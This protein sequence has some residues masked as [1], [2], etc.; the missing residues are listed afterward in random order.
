MP[1]VLSF[2]SYRDLADSLA[3]QLHA[4]RGEADALAPWTAGVIVASSG[5][6]GA[7]AAALIARI[8]S[9]IAGLPLLSMENFARSVLNAA[10]EFP[11]VASENERHLAMRTAIRRFDDPLFDSRGVSSM[12]E[13][14]YR[15]MRDAGLTLDDLAGAVERSKRLRNRERTWRILTA[16][17]EYESLIRILGAI[18]PADLFTN[19]ARAIERK[20]IVR[21][22]HVAGFYDM[23]GVQLRLVD[24]L[25][26]TG[27][28]AGVWM[29]VGAENEN[30]AYAQPLAQHFSGGAEL[31]RAK[32][33]LHA[34]VPV[35]TRHETLHDEHRG[36]CARIRTLLDDGVPARSIGI[37]SRSFE[38]WDLELLART[39]VEAGFAIRET[40]ETPLISQRI[41]RGALT[42]LRLR[43]N[44]FH[45]SDV[46]EL[47]RDGVRT[48]THASI[49]RLDAET[50]R[51]RIAG[52]TSEELRALRSKKPA[53][54]D[55]IAIVEELEGM[56]AAIDVD[57]VARLS[58][59]FRIETELDLAA[60]EAVDGIA[61]LFRRTAAW[62]RG[63]D[64]SSI[65]ELISRATLT[66]RTSNALQMIWTGDVMQ[67]RGRSFDHLFAV[68]MQHD[69][70]P[71]RRNEDPLFPD[72]DR[73]QL[74]LREIG[75]GESEER[76]L[77]QL[78]HDAAVLPVQFSFAS[79][80]GF[81]KVLRMS[82]LLR[83]F[84]VVNAA[85][86]PRTETTS[87][88]RRALQRL[89]SAGRGE[90]FDGYLRDPQLLERLRG[91]LV[92]LTP[93]Q[94]EDFG[95]CPQKFLLKHVLGARDLEDPEH[96]LQ[97]P[98][99]DKGTIDH[100]ILEK[101]Y[102][103]L[104][105]EELR[106]ALPHLPILPEPLA[107]R[108]DA[109]IDDRFDRLEREQVSFNASVRSIERDTTR[110][111]L[112]EFIARDF[113]E[114]TE[115]QLF[116]KHF[117]YRFGTRHRN[118]EEIDHPEP[119][120]VE[121]RGLRVRIEGTIDRIDSDNR[122]F[123]VID[124][125]SGKALRHADLAKKVKRGVRLQLA[126]YAMAVAEFFGAPPEAVSAA[127]KPIVAADRKADKYAFA[128][129]EQKARLEETLE[130]FAG[131]MLEGRFPAFP[132]R[133]DSEFNSCKYCPVNH[134]CRTLHDADERYAVQQHSD[135]RTLLGGAEASE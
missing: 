32:T 124:Y 111:L 22:Q 89:A 51:E 112:R 77:F 14:S 125:K 39:A 26:K 18:D 98:A 104:T 66:Q 105:R 130:I 127:I 110:R 63:V 95:E 57:F 65:A 37:T 1:H 115:Q 70:A 131:A 60:A 62:G 87:P 93:T 53:I 40:S 11:R 10:G 17:R 81:G 118:V 94:L 54:A 28:L 74:G 123:R 126:L 90:S 135:P 91:V 64:A 99:R 68:R 129:A 103:Q 120:I 69:V 67:L 109:L 20:S 92:S 7:I 19:A 71:Q 5:L 3:N 52:G 122:N 75:D 27:K 116:P 56:T 55:Y 58:S 134:S 113:V 2:S 107:S 61:D 15:D 12:L 9:G 73:R 35:V 102:R 36:V 46:I 50:R 44:G 86:A 6:S 133:N 117:E 13:R 106:D 34:G 128:L 59:L 79:S 48:N 42:L 21:P 88:S 38:E 119:F 33:R 23:T 96:E 80:D 114:L 29:P 84:A 30:Y 108:L 43:E 41:G 121:A 101:F 16:F 97:I 78:M 31:R 83:D 45:R 24:A 82:R 47:L 72:H 25:R 8:P 132:N 4:E 100:E 49:D 76:L 85:A